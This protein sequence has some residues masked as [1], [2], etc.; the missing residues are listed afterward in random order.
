MIEGVGG[1]EGIEWDSEGLEWVGLGDKERMVKGK[2]A[3]DGVGTK[4]EQRER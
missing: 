3:E 1:E 2:C 4:N